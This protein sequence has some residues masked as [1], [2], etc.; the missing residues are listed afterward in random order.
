MK[1]KYHTKR[2]QILLAGKRLPPH[3]PPP[4]FLSPLI[5]LRHEKDV[6]VVSDKKSFGKMH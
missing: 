1:R 3:S 6:A 5:P 2:L 4:L